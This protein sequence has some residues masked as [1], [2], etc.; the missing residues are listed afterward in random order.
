MLRRVLV[1]A[2]AGT[3]SIP[4]LAHA[5]AG[6]LDPSFSGDGKVLTPIPG[7]GAGYGEAIDSRGR[8]VVVGNADDAGKVA[9]A[10]YLPSGKLDASFGNDGLALF[11]F[12]TFRGVPSTGHAVAID[13]NDRVVVV[14]QTRRSQA[15]GRNI[16]IARLTAHGKLD[17]SFSGDGREVWHVGGAV[18]KDVANSVAIDSAGRIVAAGSSKINGQNPEFTLVRCRAN[19]AVDT[20]FS[21]DGVVRTSFGLSEDF[22]NGVAIDSAGRIVA[23]GVSHSFSRGDYRAAI[24]RYRS[25]GSLDPTFSG[26]GKLLLGSPS[27][28]LRALAVVVDGQDRIVTAGDSFDVNGHPQFTVIRLRSNGSLD[29]SFGDD[30]MAINFPRATASSVAIDPDGRIVAAG[31]TQLL[32]GSPSRFAIAR[33]T[34]SGEPDRSFSGDGTVTTSVD[35]ASQTSAAFA[36]AIDPLG[37]IVAAGVGSAGQGFEFAVARYLSG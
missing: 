12:S 3:L 4:A 27:G 7:G 2:V 1:L 31:Y 30:G 19:G 20:T 32:T 23:A 29:T 33:Y 35:K 26:D 34:P 17:P 37:R 15:H 14:G 9:V 10:R 16:G 13:S 18:S 6:G 28:E 36:V 24:A 5:A 22:A 8:I 25:D 21:G 11:R